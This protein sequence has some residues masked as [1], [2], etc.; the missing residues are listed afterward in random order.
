MNDQM[1][2]AISQVDAY[3]DNLIVEIGMNDLSSEERVEVKDMLVRS[4]EKYLI[5]LLL[6]KCSNE[7][8]EEVEKLADSANALEDILNY[9]RDNVADYEAVTKQGFDNFKDMMINNMKS[10]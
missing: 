3:L 9:F 2:N 6:A 10:E 5:R 4:L 7:Q 1:I 8:V